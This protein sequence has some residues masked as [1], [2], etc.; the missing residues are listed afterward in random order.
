MATRRTKR[1]ARTG[2]GGAG[3]RSEIMF[4]IGI[5]GM[6]MLVY[7][8]SFLNSGT[9]TQRYTFLVGDT[10]LL[11]V[12]YESRQKVLVAIQIEILLSIA[13]SFFS[14]VPLLAYLGVVSLAALAMIAYLYSIGYYRKDRIG[15]IGT[16]GFVVL[17]VGFVLNTGAYKF[18][19]D[20]AFAF[21]AVLIAI[22]SLLSFYFYKVRVQLV[23]FVLNVAFG[24][25]PL[26]AL[27]A[28][29]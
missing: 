11:L 24:I 15:V 5:L 3:L 19:V 29:L 23:F 12:A 28:A 8:V 14:S 27:L 10:I 20:F 22:Y 16:V 18:A 7:A 2:A 26:L 1:P 4:Y 13:A 17:A 9:P 21:G 6:L 25:A